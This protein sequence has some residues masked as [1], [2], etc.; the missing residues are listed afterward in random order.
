MKNAVNIRN[1]IKLESIHRKSIKYVFIPKYVKCNEHQL[2]QKS[3]NIFIS[4]Q[5]SNITAR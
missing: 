2:L 3:R 4:N 1:P 5:I